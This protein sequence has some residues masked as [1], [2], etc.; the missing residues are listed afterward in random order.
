MASK[1]IG[2]LAALAPACAC[3]LAGFVVEVVPA[4]SRAFQRLYASPQKLEWLKEIISHSSFYGTA[5]GGVLG[6][7]HGSSAMYAV[8]V[9]WFVSLHSFTFALASQLEELEREEEQIEKVRFRKMAG[10][11]RS[12]LRDE[13]SK[14]ASK[15]GVTTQVEKL[16][17]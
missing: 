10:M 9:L 2:Y 17:L 6:Y 1:T 15:V 14:T 16:A 11:V 4:I 8:A 13:L 12:I 5:I 3:A 7:N